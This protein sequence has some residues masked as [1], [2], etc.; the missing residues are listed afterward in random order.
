MAGLESNR[1]RKVASKRLLAQ[2]REAAREGHD[3]R[4]GTPHFWEL[5][6]AHMAV[7][8]DLC[9]AV[10]SEHDIEATAMGEEARTCES[11]DCGNQVFKKHVRGRWPLY[12][13]TCRPR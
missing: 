2:A 3:V 10:A 4:P 7:V 8:S 13:E 5:M 11:A 12:C 6:A 9:A 1:L